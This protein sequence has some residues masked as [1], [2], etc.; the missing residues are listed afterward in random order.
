MHATENCAAFFLHRGCAISSSARCDTLAC[1]AV[2]LDWSRSH[3]FGLLCLWTVSAVRPR[4]DDLHDEA[5][6]WLLARALRLATSIPN[7]PTSS[8]SAAYVKAT[9]HRGRRSQYK[10]S[11]VDTPPWICQGS[12]AVS[13][14]SAAGILVSETGAICMRL[15]R[16]RRKRPGIRLD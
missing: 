14:A 8:P 11:H 16:A 3:C 15:L 5:W 10:G 4:R 6:T 12:S 9:I 13:N 7:S 1:A 2:A